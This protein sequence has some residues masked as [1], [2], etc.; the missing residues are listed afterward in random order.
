MPE[1]NRDRLAAAALLLRPVL[2]DLVFVGGAVTGLLITDS[3]AGE[4][5]ATFDVDVIAEI[6]SY[7]EYSEFGERLR[8]LGFSE[9]TRE[10]APLCRWVNRRTVLDVMP[11]DEKVLGFS[12]RWYREAME[13]AVPHRIGVALVIRVVTAPLFLATKIEAFKSRGKSDAAFSHD[14]EDLIS[15]VDGRAAIVEE[16]RTSA[17]H[18]R[19]FIRTETA[20]LL[21]RRT[22]TDALPGYLFPDA[23]SQ[24]RAGIVIDRLTA[25]ALQ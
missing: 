13:T 3:A 7:A 24:A 21:R 10:G 5:R 19:A 16:V 22:F 1:S 20:A 9:D 17:D 4:P 18:L 6:T 8:A 25:L 2:P 11:L 12:N 14:L 15:V 23:M